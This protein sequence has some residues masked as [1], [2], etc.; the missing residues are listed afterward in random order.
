MV[1]QMLTF[2][3][4][5]KKKKANLVSPFFQKEKVKQLHF[6][7]TNMY[8][9]APKEFRENEKF[10]NIINKIFIIK[11]KDGKAVPHTHLKQCDK[12]L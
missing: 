12:K 2:I 9:F 11:D 10:W 1:L 6:N 4:P 5:D 3:C 8:I 7:F